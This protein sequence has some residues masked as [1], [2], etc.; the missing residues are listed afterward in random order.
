MNVARS[1]QIQSSNF[2]LIRRK[3]KIVEKKSLFFWWKNFPIYQKK[4]LL[5][6][7]W[8]NGRNSTVDQVKT[9]S[10]LQ[11]IASTVFERNRQSK[12]AHFVEWKRNDHFVWMRQ[13]HAD[14][15]NKRV[16]VPHLC[17]K[18]HFQRK[19]DELFG[20]TISKWMEMPRHTHAI[21]T[22][23]E[24]SDKWV[25]SK[26]QIVENSVCA[27]G[28]GEFIGI[29]YF[30]SFSPKCENA[31]LFLSKVFYFSFS[32]FVWL[33]LAIVNLCNLWSSKSVFNAEQT[34]SSNGAQFR[35]V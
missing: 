32:S 7:T 17:A 33:R 29:L 2:S 26:T 1:P 8:R 23:T 22:E 10:Q 28:K 16:G 6:F 13:P 19:I 3:I 9:L 27:D 14:D 15:E 35:N 25:K 12:I 5:L 20:F 21:L 11:W 4:I 30:S 34:Y 24:A 31:H 18:P